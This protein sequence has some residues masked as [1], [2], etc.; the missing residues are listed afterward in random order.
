MQYIKTSDTSLPSGRY[1][2]SRVIQA[3]GDIIQTDDVANTLS[4]DRPEASKLLHRW[5]RQGWLRR[6]ARGAYAPAPLDF[7]DSEYVLHDHWVLVPPLYAPAYI[8]GWSAAEYWGLTDQL[9]RETVVMTTRPV[10]QKSQVRHGAQFFLCHIDKKRFFGTT[11]VWRGRSKVLVS[12][13]PRTIIDM[14]NNPMLGGGIGH[15]ADCLCIYLREFVD[16]ETLAGNENDE[17]ETLIRYA[18]MLGNGAVFKR[19]GFL[20]E[21]RGNLPK[22][23]AACRDHLTTGNAKLNP[24]MHC[25]RLVSRWRL[26]VPDYLKSGTPYDP[27]M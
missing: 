1:K 3:S 11:T 24:G 6:V 17:S 15:V 16:K 22:L 2:L 7:L 14:L 9:F 5:T 23:V 4:V 8:G 26:W 25:D 10:R 20:A 19:L 12:D 13:V 21:K 27:Q 18:K